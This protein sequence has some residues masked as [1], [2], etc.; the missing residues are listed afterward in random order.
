QAINSILDQTLQDFEIIVSDDASTDDT[1][2]IVAQV[3]DERLRHVRQAR[4]VGIAE[5]R[6]RCLAMARGRYIAWLGSDDGYH[7][8]ML[9]VQSAVLD[10]HPQVGLVHGAC[11]VIDKDGRRL[12]DWPRPFARNVVET[13]RSAFRE[14]VLSNYITAPTVLVRRSCQAQVGPY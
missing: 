13:G 11:E 9:A 10:C 4:N 7:P 8:Q 3:R 6:N 2:A 14:L 1:P 12:P 5:N